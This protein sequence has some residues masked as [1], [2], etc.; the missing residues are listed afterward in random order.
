MGRLSIDRERGSSEPASVS[1]PG[2]RAELVFAYLA[3][4][5]RRTV[6]RDELAD[7]LWP[8]RLPDSWAAALRGVMSEVRRFLERGGLGGGEI[9]VTERSGYRLRLPDDVVVDLD[10]ARAEL[11]AARRLL[12]A[13][14]AT[15]AAAAAG[16]AAALS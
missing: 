1:L 3:A 4:E 2:R 6:S 15:A 8:E 13:G 7:A 5:H 16:H 12:T 10:A 9:L 11:A 14:D